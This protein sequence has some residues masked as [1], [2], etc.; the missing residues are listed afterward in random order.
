MSK[1]SQIEELVDSFLNYLFI[2]KGL[3]QNTINSYKHDLK[4]FAD[5]NKTLDI[6][7]ADFDSFLHNI[8]TLELSPKSKQRLVSSLKQF[9]IYL[10]QLSVIDHEFPKGVRI[11]LG[12]S[13]P[14][15]L[16]INEVDSFINFYDH[17]NFLNS[18]NKTILDF[19]YS[20]GTRV[21][22]LCNVELSDIDLDDN[23]VQ[24]KGK[25]KKYR[26]VPIGSL[27]RQNLTEY[28]TYRNNL[29]SINSFLF[30]SKSHKQMER[31]AVFRVIKKTTS[32]LG[33]GFDIHPHTFRHSAATHMLEG[34]CD[35]RTVQEFLGHSSV[36]TTQI[37]TKITKEF[38][39]EA[40]IESHPRS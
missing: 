32:N 24:L 28:L 35:L 39:E 36:S 37:Y 6:K 11:K 40:F 21:S 14:R 10:S 30:L 7:G 23:F 27:L 29:K 25:G 22:E 34:G 5:A 33:L 12:S 13:L 31:T 17:S 8:N 18:R 38:L 16:S 9:H 1:Q 15:V 4:K 19:L 3:S 2:Q 26:I 20:A